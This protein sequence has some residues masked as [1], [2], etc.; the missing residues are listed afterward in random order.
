[1]SESLPLLT[2]RA[3]RPLG[4]GMAPGELQL[5]STHIVF[6]PTGPAARVDGLRFSM[7]LRY[8][9]AAAAVP[10][11]GGWL[12]RKIPRVCLTMTDGAQWEFATAQVDEVVAAINERRAAKA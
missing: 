5:T 4:R 2:W 3:N 7:A 8:L 10:G 11:S 6:E 12:S 1:M 9:A